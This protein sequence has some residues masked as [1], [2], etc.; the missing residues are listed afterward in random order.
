MD[1]VRTPALKIFLV[2]EGLVP[3][4]SAGTFHGGNELGTNF[5]SGRVSM[6]KHFT[7]RQ[8]KE[9]LQQVGTTV[10]VLAVAAVRV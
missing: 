10:A 2:I 8:D 4:S 5:P 3:I 6:P 1:S 7:L 9:H